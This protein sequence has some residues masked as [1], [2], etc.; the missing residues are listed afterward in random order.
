[1][2]LNQNHLAHMVYICLLMSLHG[3]LIYARTSELPSL[4]KSL[5]LQNIFMVMEDAI[6]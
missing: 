2:S 3:R 5:C 4:K 6:Y 1:M